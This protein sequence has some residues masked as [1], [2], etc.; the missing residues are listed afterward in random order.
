MDLHIAK[1]GNSL[2]LRIPLEMVQQTG[3]KDG[4]TVQAELA[5]DGALVIRHGKWQRAAFAAELAAGQADLPMGESVM[6]E[7]R[8]GGRY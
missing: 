2:A 1:W 5:S 6:D 7:L 8:S 3:F 4:D